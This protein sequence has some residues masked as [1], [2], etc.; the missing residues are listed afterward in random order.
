MSH[1]FETP[2]HDPMRQRSAQKSR[3]SGNDHRPRRRRKTP[4]PPPQKFVDYR[5][6]PR[7]YRAFRAG[8]WKVWV[9]KEL[10]SAAPDLAGE[11]LAR[12]GTR[13]A[14][15]LAVL[16]ARSRPQLRKLPIF[17]LYGPE[18]RGGGRDNGLE[19]FRKTAPEHSAHL[20][21]RWK[22]CVVVYC[23]ENYLRLSEFWALKA[24]VHEFAHAHH[25]EHWPEDRPDVRQAWASAARR[26][27]YRGV[28]DDQ[29]RRREKAYAAVNHLEY[30]AELSCIYFV[31]GEYEP[32]DRQGLQTYDPAG[33]AL[34]EKMWGL[35]D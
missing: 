5:E 1:F 8:C 12:L 34:V 15:A 28:Q 17:L 21:P 3:T 20:D 2:G 6:P 25:L 13:L 7:Q 16:P 26:R 11:A 4:L 23:A 10:L 18:A 27:L 33:C 9:E 14:E 29:G 31:G 30:F 22:S 32:F 19:Y 24:L 35:R